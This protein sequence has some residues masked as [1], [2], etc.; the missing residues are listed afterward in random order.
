MDCGDTIID[1]GTEVRDARGIVISANVVPGA[2]RMVKDLV[3][4]GFRVALVADGRYASFENVLTQNGLFDA[5]ETLTCSEAVRYPKP[6]SR[7]FKAALG[8]LDLGEA[9]AWRCVMVGNNLAR[10]IAGAKRMGITT[11]H[12][13]WTGRY[14][15]EPASTAEIADYTIKTPTELLPLVHQLDEQLL[16]RAPQ[17][18]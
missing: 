14:P 2:D 13:A 18:A 15:K 12:L 5:F 6:S 10:D 7:M 8:S 3:D 9:D 17:P 11:I 1:E 4:S 16:A